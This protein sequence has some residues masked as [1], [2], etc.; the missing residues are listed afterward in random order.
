MDPLSHAVVG[1]S[2]AESAR[3]YGRV[4]AA[5]F[6]SAVAAVAPDLDVLV[7]SSS[8]PLLYLEYHRTFTHALCFVP[9]GAL[10][11]AALTW[12]FVRRQLTRWHAYLLSVLGYTSHL[13]LDACTTYGTQLLWPFSGTRIA[14][15]AIAFI[16]LLFLGPLLALAAAAY[17]RRRSSYARFALVWAA[18]YLAFGAFQNQRAAA[19]AAALAASRSHVPARLFV[20]PA[21]FSLLLWKTVYEYDGR[22]YVDAVRAGRVAAPIPGESIPRLD[23]ARDFPLLP[24]TS[25]QALDVERFRRV[26]DGW[27]A[28]DPQFPDR[29]I[30]LRYSLV[31]NEIAGFWAIA[32][33]PSAALEEHVDYVSTREAAPQQA[34]RL[35]D[36]L[37]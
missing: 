36:M 30:D 10:L 11:C 16:D 8:D 6:V 18:A 20:T 1:A 31:P 17:F 25:Q 3:D 33:D 12:P 22:Y 37:F 29:V 5:A 23:I 15:N 19:A 14:W 13:L 34:M 28:V 2:L 27:L 9:L 26:S 7:R 21:L 35:L 4:R 24:P 32:L